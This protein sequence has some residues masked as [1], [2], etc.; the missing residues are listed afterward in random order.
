MTADDGRRARFDVHHSFCHKIYAA[1]SLLHRADV[2]H[3]SRGAGAVADVSRSLSSASLARA[4][5]S[6]DRAR[7]VVPANERVS[8]FVLQLPVHV[9]LRASRGRD[10]SVVARRAR[11]S[12]PP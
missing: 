1:R 2:E 7:T 4:R 3:C 11:A 6:R 12:R 9:L 5:L 10:P 8:V